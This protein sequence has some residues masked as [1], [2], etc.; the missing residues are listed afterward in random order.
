M[1]IH[2][3]RKN[4]ESLPKYFFSSSKFS[5]DDLTYDTGPQNGI[6]YKYIEIMNY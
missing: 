6:Q 3:N 4:H 2:E 1:K 5:Q